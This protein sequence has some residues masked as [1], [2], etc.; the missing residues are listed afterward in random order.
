M[1]L[2]LWEMNGMGVF[3]FNW[4]GVLLNFLVMEIV[5]HFNVLTYVTQLCDCDR[6]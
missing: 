2:E 6:L 1:G 3:F 4:N 5:F